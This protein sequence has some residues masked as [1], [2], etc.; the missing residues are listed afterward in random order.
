[1]HDDLAEQL[2]EEN[3]SLADVP[4]ARAWAWVGMLTRGAV[5]LVS[6]GALLLGGFA[7]GTVAQVVIGCNSA[8]G[9]CTAPP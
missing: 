1:M 4:A 3:F 6:V 9:T 8:H 2:V 7:L 5:L